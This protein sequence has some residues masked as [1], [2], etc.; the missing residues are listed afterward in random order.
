MPRSSVRL[1]EDLAFVGSR[2]RQDQE[3]GGADVVGGAGAREAVD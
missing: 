1:V 2:R 3:I